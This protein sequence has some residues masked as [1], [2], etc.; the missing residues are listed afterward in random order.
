VHGVG[1]EGKR[2]GEETPG[3]LDRREPEHQ[4]ESSAERAPIGRATR[5][6]VVPVSGFAHKALTRREKE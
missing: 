2:I 6:R 5:V 1:E 3:D 4:G